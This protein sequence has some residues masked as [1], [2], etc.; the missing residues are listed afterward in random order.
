[1]LE[2]DPETQMPFVFQ[3][4]YQHLF[5]SMYLLATLIDVPYP[6]ANLLLG[7]QQPM[8]AVQMSKRTATQETV[9][10]QDGAESMP[11]EEELATTPLEEKR[12][13]EPPLET[14]I[15]TSQL[16]ETEATIEGGKEEV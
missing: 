10:S 5:T 12:A 3:R 2:V 13:E 9:V 7:Q 6:P 15:N 8:P 16:E 4:V 14:T 1:M 11:P